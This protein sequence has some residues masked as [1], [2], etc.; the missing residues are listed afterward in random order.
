MDR[1]VIDGYHEAILARLDHFC[2]VYRALS[3]GRLASD[4]Q[5]VASLSCFF[6]GSKL[7]ESQESKTRR[8][9]FKQPPGTQRHKK[10]NANIR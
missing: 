9:G 7:P 4:R 8:N 1:R 2:G 10:H 5:G 3:S 6:R